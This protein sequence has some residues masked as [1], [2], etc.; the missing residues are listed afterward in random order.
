MTQKLIKRTPLHTRRLEINGYY[1]DDNLWDI[2]AI[3][4]DTRH[5]GI[6]T[7]NRNIPKGSPL[8][9]MRLTLTLN[10]EMEIVAVFAK[11][12]ASPYKICPHVNDSYQK[13]IGERIAPG[14]SAR[15]K[16]M[17]KGVMGCT[18]ITEMLI[19]MG[20]VAYQTIKS[21]QGAKLSGNAAESYYL[22]S[23]YAWSSGSEVY[24]N[25]QGDVD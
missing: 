18:H 7:Y 23:C 11:T 8:H 24:K 9:E 3:L 22:N 15:V 6:K 5:Y 19:P 16:T 4:I 2:E 21:G 14:W 10:F 12:D 1:R 13:L 25:A 20:T 17:F